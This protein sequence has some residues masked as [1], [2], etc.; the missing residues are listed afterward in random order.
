MWPYIVS[1][2]SMEHVWHTFDSL[3]N[4]IIFFL[5]GAL[6]GETMVHSDFADYV[7]LFVIY[8]VIMLVRGCFIFTSRPFLSWLSTDKEPVSTADALVM[9]WGG[10]RGAVGLALAIQVRNDRAQKH[11]VYMIEEKQAMRV[12]FFVS[13]IAFLTTIINAISAPALVQ[14]LEITAIPRAQQRLLKMV[15]QQLVNWSASNEIPGQVTESLRH[16]LVEIEKKFD[17]E[18]SLKVNLDVPRNSLR[19]SGSS[20]VSRMSSSAKDKMKNMAWGNDGEDNCDIVSRLQTAENKFEATADSS[21][22]L[23]DFLPDETLLQKVAD[24]TELITDKGFDVAMTKVV[25]KA[26]LS[27]LSTQYW[28]EISAGHLQPGSEQANI[29]LTSIRVSLSP[30]KA[31]L[32]DLRIVEKC[33]PKI[34]RADPSEWWKVFPEDSAELAAMKASV[35]NQE[36]SQ[37]DQFIRSAPF[38]LIVGSAILLNA[39]WVAVEEAIRTDHDTS[40]VWLVADILFTAF[41][42]LEFVLKFVVQKI[43][44]FKDATNIFDFILVV[45][46][47]VGVIVNIH[48][49]NE[50]KASTSEARTIRIARV[51][52]MLRFLRVFRLFHA[53][54]SQDKQVS[55]EVG[56]HMTRI[57]ALESFAYSH[58]VS[59]M[60]L[61]K[62]FAGNG[63]IDEDHE[64][65]V[66]RCILQSQLQVYRALDL[67]VHE[68][69]QIAPPLRAAI[70][71]VMK[72]K[73]I[74]EKLEHFVMDAMHD[75]AIS[76]RDAETIMHPLHHQISEIMQELNDLDEGIIGTGSLTPHLRL[77]PMSDE[78]NMSLESC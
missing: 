4:I 70:A 31:D 6:T 8:I 9:T 51:F 43:K 12:L 50:K 22:D 44:Y 29:L 52:R 40:L 45:L 55:L 3:G 20:F 26:F 38:N 64:I 71:A 53:K 57:H 48:A 54:W 60:K 39:V 30:L 36:R 5:A 62:Y 34:I 47:I 56:S 74:T 2:E 35:V 49:Q 16:T 59:Q 46:G 66:G 68:N 28:K 33:L 73:K 18:N 19:P 13:G 24:I 42:F 76:A 7:H 67:I 27:M 1:S 58:L 41:F 21:Y 11:G 17:S 14:W 23:L 65:E 77:P 69:R 10:L 25:N 72:R 37:L 32:N 63:K 75:G 78:K 61:V 15:Y